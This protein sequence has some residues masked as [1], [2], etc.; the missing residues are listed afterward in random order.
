MAV[1]ARS[2]LVAVLVLAAACVPTPEAPESE[3]TSQPIVGGTPNTG[4]PAIMSLV[5]LM[6]PRGAR[7]TATLITPRLLLTAA[8]CIFETPGFSRQ[9]FTGN[10]DQNGDAPEKLAVKAV[11]SNPAYQ[12]APRQGND[13][14]IVV[15]EAPLSIPTVRLNRAAIE[16]A[17]GKT[18]RYVGY[19]LMTVGNPLSGGIKRH[20]TAPLA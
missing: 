12:G 1:A 15:L 17:Q 2:V 20:N 16:S 5:S 4:D 18:V 19:G 14:C 7:C 8:H 9:I 10:N 6:G 13:F 11:V 3:S